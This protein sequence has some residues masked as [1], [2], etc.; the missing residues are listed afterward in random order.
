MSQ[1]KRR[2]CDYLYYCFLGLLI[3]APIPLGANRQFAWS[4]LTLASSVLVIA[5]VIMYSMSHVRVTKA[6]VYGKYSVIT[7][8]VLLVWL[9][10]QIIPLP[11]VVVELVS[12]MRLELDKFINSGSNDYL[13]ISASPYVSLNS[14]IKYV[15]YFNAF[16]LTL[17]LVDS[18]ERFRKL[19]W[20][21]VISGTIQAFYGSV[22][23]LTGAEK[24]LWLDKKAYIGYATGTFVNRN[25][26]AGY[27]VVCILTGFG[28]MLSMMK[29]T[30]SASWKAKLRNIL[31]LLFGNK[32]RLRVF[33]VVMVIGIVMSG[34]RMGNASLVLTLMIGGVLGYMFIRHAR[35]SLLIL[36]V[37]VAII[38]FVVVGVWMGFEKVID[39]LEGSFVRINTL[40]SEQ[41]N[42]SSISKIEGLSG[43]NIKVSD[44]V[45]LLLVQRGHVYK[46][47]KDYISD[48][49]LVGSGIGTFQY[50]YPM[51]RDKKIFMFFNHAHNDYMEFRAEIGLVGSILLL[52]VV[53]IT[54][55][56]CLSELW[57]G[58]RDSK[59]IVYIPILVLCG[60]GI[61]ASVEFNLQI[62]AYMYTICVVMALSFVP[63]SLEKRVL[64]T[65]EK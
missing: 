13:S 30:N 37:S 28:L 32:F 15:A 27:L 20:V 9:I 61:H 39:R 59:V 44:A 46:D 48:Y 57:F 64:E 25:H 60:A 8:V 5:W 23:V 1:H 51:Y 11:S 2:A 53:L 42:D 16:I 21:I 34:S 54:I 12:P 62:P 58:S 56:Q 49:Y 10:V 14:F 17:L 38:D 41:S 63:R 36:V 26:F 19:A 55:K 22:M 7:F 65:K 4:I 24:I 40:S 3:V 43:T 18:R 29:R 6:F 50:M 35:K 33:L 45:Y 52:I 47:M 31:L